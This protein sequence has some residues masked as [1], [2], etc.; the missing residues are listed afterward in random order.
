MAEDHHTLP[1]PSMAEAFDG[2]C[3]EKSYRRKE[4]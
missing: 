4:G 3:Q 2:P 1:Q